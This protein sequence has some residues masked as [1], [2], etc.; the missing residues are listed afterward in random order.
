MVRKLD[1]SLGFVFNCNFINIFFDLNCLAFPDILRFEYIKV[2]VLPKYRIGKL[3][4]NEFW[5]IT[6]SGHESW[7]RVQL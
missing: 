3:K 7:F 4:P 2:T 6:K 1:M 5:P